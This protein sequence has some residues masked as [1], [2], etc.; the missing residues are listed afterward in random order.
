MTIGQGIGIRLETGQGR[1]HD[2]PVPKEV[3]N[4]RPYL[5]Q[6][7]ILGIR[8]EKIAHLFPDQ[9]TNPH[10]HH[11]QCTVKITEPTGPDTLVSVLVN[12][13][14]VACRVQPGDARPVG[15]EMSLAIDMS[16]AIFFAPDTEVKIQ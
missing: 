10:I 16:K 8:P 7:V 11:L 15:E 1:I 12:Q 6:T 9:D 3:C 4:L 2:V 14:D 5:G 13:T